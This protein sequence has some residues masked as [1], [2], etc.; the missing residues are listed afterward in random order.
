VFGREAK[1][2]FEKERGGKS[3]VKSKLSLNKAI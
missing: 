2:A 1:R 3:L